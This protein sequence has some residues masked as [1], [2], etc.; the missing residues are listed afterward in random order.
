ML[1]KDTRFD[2]S[3]ILEAE[4]SNSTALALARATLIALS[5]MSDLMAGANESPRNHLA[6]QDIRQEGRSQS[7]SFV[8]T[9]L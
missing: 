1:F 9:F 6:R 7:H 5:M 4:N 2:Y 8:T 3:R